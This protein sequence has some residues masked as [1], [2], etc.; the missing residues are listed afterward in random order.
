M[1]SKVRATSG[2]RRNHFFKKRVEMRK[3]MFGCFFLASLS[4]WAQE[5]A[6]NVQK[7][8]FDSKLISHVIKTLG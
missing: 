2:S 1:E 5:D 3:L 8:K 4:S 6:K 7:A